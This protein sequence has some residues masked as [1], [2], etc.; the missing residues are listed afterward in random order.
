MNAN[1]SRFGNDKSAEYHTANR[2]EKPSGEA[3]L[4][5]EN[6]AELAGSGGIAICQA[7]FSDYVRKPAAYAAA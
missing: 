7:C 6:L 2:D 3:G 1:G 4:V 5:I